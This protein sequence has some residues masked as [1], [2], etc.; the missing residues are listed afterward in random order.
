MA[1]VRNKRLD[2][3]R[4]EILESI[5]I[6]NADNTDIESDDECEESMSPN[7]IIMNEYLRELLDDENVL[8]NNLEEGEQLQRTNDPQTNESYP[9]SDT[10]EIPQ[11]MP[12]SSRRSIE[13]E[14]N[15]HWK[16]KAVVKDYNSFMG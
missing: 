3:D 9:E 5:P 8:H 13:A 6:D 2:T 12:S 1:G 10:D 15:R 4:I 14:P 7:T 16:L 11:M